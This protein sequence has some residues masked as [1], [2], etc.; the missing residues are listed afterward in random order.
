MVAIS[1]SEMWGGPSE[2]EEIDRISLLWRRLTGREL[3][4]LDLEY[5]E[6]FKDA[7]ISYRAIRFGIQKTLRRW[8]PKFEG[9]RV[10]HLNYC[11]TEIYEAGRAEAEGRLV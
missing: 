2:L 9:D 11:Q 4:A 6:A 5:I 3:S 1:D 10:R 8:R 7:G